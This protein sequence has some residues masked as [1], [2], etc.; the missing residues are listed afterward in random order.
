M[1]IK[2]LLCISLLGGLCL[3]GHTAIAAPE[4]HDPI[5]ITLNDWTGELIT[6][7]IMGDI[8]KKAGY[9]IDYIPADY[10]AQFSGME[11]GDLTVAPEVWATTAQEA[12]QAAVK[13]GKVEDLGSS[14]MQAR[15]EWWFPEYM[16]EKCPGLPN[17][18]ALK[19]CGEIFSTPETAP[20]GRYLGGP[21]TWGG[22]DEERIEALDL[23]FEV[24]H[25]GTDAALFAELK[26]AY[27]RKA[28]IILWIYTPHWVPIKYKGEFVEFPRYEP[29][30]YEDPSWGI[31]K[32][33]KYD[34]G[35]PYGPI[36]KAVWSGM[37]DKWP[38]AYTII[39]NY[40]FDNKTMGELDAR[41]DL[42]GE[43]VED[44][45]QDWVNKHEDV[46]KAWLSK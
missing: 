29:G 18:E 41:V 6:A 10:L 35:K 3:M 46:W 22:H 11:N 4:S 17:W 7:H 32:D 2:N 25:A 33:A 34:C 13:T 16:K 9:N 42:D 38:G 36:W 45:A 27:E 30:C 24:V 8:L 14:G 31:N 28:P 37:K 12:L 44:V 40:K 39:K 5:K 21:S 1:M 26:S 19:K 43:K 23:P 20:K 15:E